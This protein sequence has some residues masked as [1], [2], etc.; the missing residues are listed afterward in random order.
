MIF[1]A[2]GPGEDQGGEVARMAW[3]GDDHG[4]ESWPDLDGGR[5]W[6][7]GMQLRLHLA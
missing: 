6:V 4:C 1:I 5:W 3:S 7:L 2:S